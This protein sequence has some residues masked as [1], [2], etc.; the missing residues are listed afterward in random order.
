M[1]STPPSPSEGP[2]VSYAIDGVGVDEATFNALFERLDVDDEP[3]EGES[4]VEPDG[5]YGGAG[6]SFHAR[7]GNVSY[8]YECHTYPR[9]DGREGQSRLL[10]RE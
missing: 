5:S 6:E 9:E 10:F 2:V 8:R 1:P 4:V 7:E 3:Y